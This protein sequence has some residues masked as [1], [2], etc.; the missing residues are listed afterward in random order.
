MKFMGAIHSNTI[1][2]LDCVIIVRN[3][4]IYISKKTLTFNP[5]PN[6]RFCQV[7]LESYGINVM[8]V[9]NSSRE[10]HASQILRGLNQSSTS[11]PTKLVPMR[12]VGHFSSRFSPKLLILFF[13]PK[14]QISQF[15]LFFIQ[16]KFVQSLLNVLM[17]YF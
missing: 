5:N 10:L 3:L 4:V 11:G 2:L 8:P 7:T 14:C 6:P 13:R 9:K 15:C 16:N 1:G 17:L 12:S